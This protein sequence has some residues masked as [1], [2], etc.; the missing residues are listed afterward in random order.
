MLDLTYVR[1]FIAVADEMH[2]GRAAAPLTRRIAKGEAGLVRLGFTAASAYQALPRLVTRI[3]AALPGIDLVLEEMVTAEQIAALETQ[4]L[5][6]G[7]LRPSPAVHG[8]RARITTASLL[9]E[10]LLLAVPH[11]HMLATGRRPV[12]QDLDE[13]P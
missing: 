13:Q 8:S 2:F 7:L 5:D 9:R 4:R 6:L 10:R 12:L 1:S 11:N 3:R